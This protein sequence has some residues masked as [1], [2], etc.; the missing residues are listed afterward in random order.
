[1]L[2]R[3]GLIQAAEG[4]MGQARMYVRLARI[5]ARVGMLMVPLS[6]YLGYQI[7]SEGLHLLLDKVISIIAIS[8][9]QGV[10]PTWDYLTYTPLVL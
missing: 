4:C 2:R 3:K 5:R 8:V 9:S 10:C 7:D 6:S 1:M